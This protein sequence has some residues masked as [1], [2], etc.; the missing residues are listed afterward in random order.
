MTTKQTVAAVAAAGVLAVAGAGTGLVASN[1]TTAADTTTTFTVTTPIPPCTAVT[2]R[3]QIADPC[4]QLTATWEQSNRN[5]LG[6]MAYYPKWKAASPG[7]YARL[8]A[9]GTSAETTPEPSA[10]SAFGA[11]VRYHLT[12]CRTW[13]PDPS[14]CS[15]P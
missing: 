13:T 2:A 9:W 3:G 5:A 6:T 10:A 8:K 11:L 1:A 12:I 4:N 15:I 14:R 7:E